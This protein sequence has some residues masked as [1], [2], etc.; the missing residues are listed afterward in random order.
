MFVPC[1]QHLS[2]EK[3]CK[4]WLPDI[5]SYKIIGCYCQ[6][7]LGHGSDVQSLET[8]ATY[9]ETTQQFIINSPT[10]SSTKWWVGELGIWCTHAAVF[11][12]LI[13]KGKKY[14]V[15][16]FFVPI[17]DQQNYNPLPG[18]QVGDIGPKV[19]VSVKDNGFVRFNNVRIPRENMLMRYQ[20]V[21]KEGVF[22][23][24]GN[25]KIGY[26]VMVQTRL[27]ISTFFPRTLSIALTVAIRYSLLRK[28]FKDSKGEER[29]ILDYQTQQEK[30][31][32]PLAEIY[33]IL[34]SAY[35]IQDI[36]LNLMQ[37]VQ[38]NDFS[39]LNET[40]IVVSGAKATWTESVLHFLEIIRL[41]CGGHGFS[42]Y[43][44][45]PG[46]VQEWKPMV[47]LEGDNTILHMQ[48]ARFLLK[49]AEKAMK[50]LP[51]GFSVQYMKII[52]EIQGTKLENVNTI[53]E[54]SNLQVL[55]KIIVASAIFHIQS[56]ANKM[57]TFISSGKGSREA[58]DKHTGIEL[59]E[60]SKAHFLVFTVMN[61]EERIQQETQ[62]NVKNVLT[63]LCSLF[64]VTKILS[65]P[66][67]L[68]ENEY[69]TGHHLSLLQQIKDQMLSEIRNDALALVEAFGYQ[70]MQLRSAIGSQNGEIYKNLFNWA[71]NYNSINQQPVIDGYEWIQ[72]LKNLHAS[73]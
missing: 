55:Q 41:A 21:S 62:E 54:I 7:E 72:K 37:R 20:K 38:K 12:Q 18:I 70:D 50:G 15:Y 57:L 64:A 39:T 28:Q 46:M 61:F 48:V 16:T 73:L 29:T 25:P 42:Q 43:S 26:A 67:Q 47:T 66:I 60:A 33:A 4:Q 1:I 22:T 49:Q 10:V 8:T 69:I 2:S 68:I 30:L 14:G 5:Y 11:A 23:Q 31:F 19:G 36:F 17:R 44:G 13:I 34:I 59:V 40:H 32:V 6:T 3:Q 63:K 51:L 27:A 56:A 53:N 45:L 52:S 24:V 35:R 65:K 9:D 71:K 58:W